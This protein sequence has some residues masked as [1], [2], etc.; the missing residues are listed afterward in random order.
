MLKIIKDFSDIKINPQNT[1]AAFEAYGDIKNK[2]STAATSAADSIAKTEKKK[3][4]ISLD[5]NISSIS[6]ILFFDPTNL[7]GDI[8]AINTGETKIFSDQEALKK[9]EFT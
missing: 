1:E 7:N 8:W 6:L 4:L 3:N 5:V 2:V 9:L